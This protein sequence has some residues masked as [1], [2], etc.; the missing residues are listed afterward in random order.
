[1]VGVADA[2]D[3][4]VG[5]GSF[6]AVDHVAEV[7]GVDEQDLA[8]AVDRALFADGLVFGEEPQADRDS[9][10]I[11]NSCVGRAIMQETRS[12]SAI[13]R[14]MS[15]SPFELDDMEP[16]ARTT[17]LAPGANLYRCLYC[18]SQA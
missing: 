17:Q 2:D 3:V 11:W 13:S 1:M 4:V 18:C 5:E 6:G 10:G 7:A 12:A 14:R 8:G 16:L 9:G 15:P